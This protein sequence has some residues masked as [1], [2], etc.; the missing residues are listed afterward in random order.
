MNKH[1]SKLAEMQ[2]L[3]PKQQVRRRPPPDYNVWQTIR[4]D[5]DTS[6]GED[7][8]ILRAIG[9]TAIVSADVAVTALTGGAATSLVGFAAGGAITAKRLGDGIEQQDSKEVAKILVVYGSATT[10]SLVGQIVT[11][12]Y[13]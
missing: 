6:K 12:L 1:T 4:S 3:R 7:R 11:E 5:L 9:R 2:L 10:A 13:W 8:K